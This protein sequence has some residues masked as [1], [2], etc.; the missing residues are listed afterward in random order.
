M[1]TTT[2]SRFGGEVVLGAAPLVGFHAGVIKGGAHVVGLKPPGHGLG[3]VAAEA[4]D[5]GRLL[6]MAAEN[7]QRLGAGVDARN[8]SIDEI[9]TIEVAD[10]HGRILQF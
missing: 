10:Q 5:D 4:V 3:V 1:A 6:G 2:S 7:F 9:R 8:N